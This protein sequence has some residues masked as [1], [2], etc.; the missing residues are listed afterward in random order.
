MKKVTKNK[1][2]VRSIFSEA[3]AQR[4]LLVLVTPYLRFV[5]NF[6]HLDGDEIHTRAMISREGALYGLRIADLNL[7]FQHKMSF[8]EAP[9]KLI[10]FGIHEGQK[11]IRFSL[12]KLI[13]EN[14]ERKNIRIERVGQIMATFSTPSLRFIQASLVDISASGAQL[15]AR[16]VLPNDVLSVNDKIMLSFSLS[17]D[18]DINNSAIVRHKTDSTFGVEFSPRLP[19]S[20]QE[21]LAS[22]IFIKRE[23][24]YDFMA[25]NAGTDDAASEES[26][27]IEGYKDSGGGI[28]LVTRDADVDSALKNLLAENINFYRAL[29]AIAPMKDA[30]TKK[31]NLVILHLADSKMEEKRLFKSLA[32]T[33]RKGV[34]ILLL[35]TGM[36]IEQLS[37]LGQDFKAASSIIWTPGKNPFLQRLVMGILRRHYGHG[38]SPMAPLEAE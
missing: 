4:E 30:L 29:P 22:W 26:D 8:L 12:P 10:G 35:G 11:T 18:I 36:E 21:P 34:P 6:I 25:R 24:T 28:L 20:I 17:K 2:R 19:D 9:S 37:E 31:P 38:E 3:C 32:E 5:T 16:E 23:E 13:Y 7:R 15:T 14:D 27:G 33:I 1:E